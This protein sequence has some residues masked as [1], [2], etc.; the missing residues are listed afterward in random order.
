ME[1]EKSDI[2]TKT[3]KWELF[4]YLILFGFLILNA[5]MIPLR[6]IAKIE[7]SSLYLGIDVLIG[8]AFLAFSL[9]TLDKNAWKKE[10]FYKGIK[11]IE[12]LSALPYE[13][14]AFQLSGTVAPEYLIPLRF[15]TLMKFVS[16]RKIIPLSSHISKQPKF[17]LLFLSISTVVHWITCGWIAINNSVE[18]DF[19]TQYNKALYWTITT[20]TTVGYGDI[21]PT[22]NY[23][24]LYTVFVM[25]GGVT[26]F[27]LI[28]SHFF[29]LM[30]N[31]DK[32]TKHKDEQMDKLKSFLAY[33]DIPPKL[34]NDVF[35]FYGHV[36]EKN[37]TEEDSQILN[38]LPNSLQDELTIYMKIK[39]ITRI[40]IFEGLSNKCLKLIAKK[41]ELKDYSPDSYI[42]NK[43]ELGDKMYIIAHG[44]V[45]VINNGHTIGRLGEGQFFGEIAL[46]ED[47]RRVA[48]V[49]TIGYCDIYTLSKDDFITI[50]KSFPELEQR[51]YKIYQTPSEKRKKVA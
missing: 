27:G 21:A 16:I 6:V 32:Y 4:A 46:I 31:K 15:V 14:I 5:T 13:L 37:I 20:L 1:R 17:I 34:K 9:A 50:T 18:P 42:I 36:L 45:E 10:K 23:S 24:R 2:F 28:L 8:I 51:F 44:G 29:K 26:S 43:D 49:K 7:L 38:S 41:L 3:K 22:T 19:A 25:L 30:L 11:L 35:S 33:Y 12:I 47:T 40:H 39:L 48:D